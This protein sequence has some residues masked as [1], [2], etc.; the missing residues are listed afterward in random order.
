MAPPGCTKHQSRG[1]SRLDGTHFNSPIQAPKLGHLP[2]TGHLGGGSGAH[3]GLCFDRGGCRFQR[4][5][6][7]KQR[8]GAKDGPNTSHGRVVKTRG[9]S[10][11]RAKT[12]RDA[13]ERAGQWNERSDTGFSHPCQGQKTSLRDPSVSPAGRLGTSSG[14]A[15]IWHVRGLRQ[16]GNLGLR[17]LHPFG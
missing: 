12:A 14:S 10:P 17:C 11:E 3:G 15:H 7:N 13:N 1:G 16:W 6:R 2:P 9:S 8:N 5:G 4:H